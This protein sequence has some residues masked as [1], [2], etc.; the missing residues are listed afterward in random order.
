MIAVTAAHSPGPS[1]ANQD[2]IPV[3]KP[4]TSQ[5]GSW[6]RSRS[7]KLSTPSRVA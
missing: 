4:T 1:N 2:A 6:P 3:P 7:R 5:E